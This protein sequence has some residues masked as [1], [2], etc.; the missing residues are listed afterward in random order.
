MVTAPDGKAKTLDAV[1]G[2]P[3]PTITEADARRLA[4]AAYVGSG[5]PAAARFY[6][7]APQETG[8]EGPL[9]RVDFDDAERTAFYLSPDTGEVVTR[10]SD[11]WRFYDFFWRLHI[12]DFKTGDNFNHPLL[13][14]LAV[15]TLPVVLT[16]FILL[17]IRLGRDLAVALDRR[18]STPRPRS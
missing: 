3:V 2:Q 16:G 4:A 12:L 11:V 7:A 14:A 10:R 9:W 17:W 8:R 18:R 13:I 15:L 1:T 6:P 5:V